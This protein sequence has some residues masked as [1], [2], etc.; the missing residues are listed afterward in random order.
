MS[1]RILNRIV[2]WGKQGIL[3]EADQRHVE[4][5]LREMGIEESSREV[6]TPCDKSLEDKK[7]ANALK[8]C[9][10]EE[11]KL[12]SCAATRYRGMTAG[13]NYLGQDRSEIQFAIKE[14]SK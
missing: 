8:S 9:E 5:C 13:I 14:L 12:E 4:I 6:A 11:E 10:E 3:Y 1:I 2:E 7:N